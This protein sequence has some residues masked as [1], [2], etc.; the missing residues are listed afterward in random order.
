MNE[1]AFKHHERL[2]FAARRLSRDLCLMR[3][4]AGLINL[5]QELYIA[6]QARLFYLTKARTMF[7]RW[8]RAHPNCTT[9]QVRAILP[10]CDIPADR[11]SLTE[12]IREIERSA[13]T[14]ARK[15][16][17]S[18][19]PQDLMDYLNEEYSELR[20]RLAK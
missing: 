20:K 12:R 18:N 3:N 1:L 10:Q 19:A 8:L 13:I 5:Y 15:N 17:D 11:E 6:R 4:E 7:D 9:A 16:R 14:F 2:A